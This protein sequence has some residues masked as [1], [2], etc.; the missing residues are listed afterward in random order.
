[1]IIDVGLWEIIPD[2]ADEIDTGKEARA[3]GG[4]TRGAAEKI[5]MFGKRGFYGVQSNGSNDE[6]RHESLEN[7]SHKQKVTEA[8][9]FWPFRG[10]LL[11]RG[12]RRRCFA[13]GGCRKRSRHGGRRLQRLPR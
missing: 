13:I 9:T 6:N 12:N 8:V 2:H 1:E 3:H 10:L 5:G 4:I 11:L 7:K